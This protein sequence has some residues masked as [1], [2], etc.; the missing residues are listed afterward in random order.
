MKIAFDCSAAQPVKGVQYNGGG[1][2]TL[3]V[4]YEL[5]KHLNQGKDEIIILKNGQRGRND[6]LE[7]YVQL[8]QLA[9]YVYPNLK[10]LNEYCNAF[11]GD[12]IYFPVCFPN[13]AA[14]KIKNEVRVVGGI[15]DMSSYYYAALG[16]QPGRYYKYNLASLI[17]YILNGLVRSYRMKRSLENHKR[18]FHFNRRTEIYTVSYYSRS[19]LLFF[20]PEERVTNV[21]YPPLKFINEIDFSNEAAVL[22]KFCIK[23]QK[24]I[25][26][27]NLS[28][29]H[30]N[31][32]RVIRALNLLYKQRLIPQDYT[33]VLVGCLE[34]QKKYLQKQA[35]YISNSL[36]ML[37][38]IS[39]EELEIL[40]KNAYIYIYASLLEGFGS[41]P[42]EAMRYGTVSVC[43]TGTSI[44]EICGDAAIYFNPLELE[45]IQMAIIR[46][47]DSQ[48][49]EIMKEKNKKRFYEITR[50]QSEDFERLIDYL[51]GM[52]NGNKT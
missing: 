28:R 37:G 40:Y 45:S 22:S 6:K 43:S 14:L 25:L 2:Y 36:V 48:Y 12:L 31:N 10:N 47:F 1:E 13:F 51:E 38:F 46:A 15:H 34:G 33:I 35:P 18:L 32:I 27:T 29:W 49:Y 5:V 11:D 4:L 21:F 7:K 30:K 50:R 20:F 8:R 44:P 52:D 3:T 26:L 39:A 24:Y 19:N 9:F 42:I 17:K 23:P 41:P 16:M